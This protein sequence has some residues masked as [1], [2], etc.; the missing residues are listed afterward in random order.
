MTPSSSSSNC[1]EVTPGLRSAS[2]RV[3][4]QTGV[5]PAANPFAV[6]QVRR[7]PCR[8]SACALRGSSRRSTAAAPS[9]SRQSVLSAMW[10]FSRNAALHQRGRCRRA[11]CRACER[12][13]R[14]SGGT[15]R[16][17]R[18]SRRPSARARRRTD[19]PCSRPCGSPPACPSR[20]KTRD[21]GSRSAHSRNSAA[22]ARN[23]SSI[24]SKPASR[25]R[26]LPR[27]GDVVTGANPTSQ[28]PISSVRCR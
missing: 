17:R 20:S 8:R 27:F 19:T 14:R 6:V 11:P 23:C 26:I 5:G 28:K 18:R 10:C 15:A 2:S 9:T 25:D 3:D 24:A 12:P 1:V 16:R 13:T 7:A 22:S 21:A 4:L